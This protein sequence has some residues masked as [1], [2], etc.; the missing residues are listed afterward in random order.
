M[1]TLEDHLRDAGIE[2]L[3]AYNCERCGSENPAFAMVQVADT[4]EY[5]C[6]DCHINDLSIETLAQEQADAAAR[7]A[8][9]PW[10]CEAGYLVKAQRN[11]LI[12]ATR[13]AA[14]PTTTP[15]AEPKRL[16]FAAYIRTL[17]RLTVDHPSPD[18]VVMPV[19]P[20]YGAGDYA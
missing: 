20:S 19:P 12:E 4:D 6:T 1:I 14:D 8:L 7:V 18:A 3:V 2:P 10:D 11:A 17:N 5:Q 9:N 16:E 13:W 15:F